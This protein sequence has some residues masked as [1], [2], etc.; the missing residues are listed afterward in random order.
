MRPLLLAGPR[1]IL[2]LPTPPVDLPLDPVDEGIKIR[3]P[4]RPEPGQRPAAA[5]THALQS[6]AQLLRRGRVHPVGLEGAPVPGR[7]PAGAEPRRQVDLS[8]PPLAPLASH[9]GVPFNAST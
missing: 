7:Q 1:G 5:S 9:G 3:P 6:L 2:S 4:R 8:R